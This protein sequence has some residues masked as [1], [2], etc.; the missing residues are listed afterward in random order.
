MA[1][2]ILNAFEEKEGIAYAA[3]PY[4]HAMRFWIWTRLG[5][6]CLG[7]SFNTVADL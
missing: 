6:V 1:L 4:H 2:A 7:S 5:I 3:G